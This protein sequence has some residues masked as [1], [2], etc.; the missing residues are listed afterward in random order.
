M[1]ALCAAPDLIQKLVLNANAPNAER[2]CDDTPRT[3]RRHTS[4]EA[5]AAYE[6]GD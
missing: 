2:M 5:M 1:S 3:H 6:E 4:H